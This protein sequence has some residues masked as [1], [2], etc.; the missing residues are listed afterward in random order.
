M[1]LLTMGKV[2]VA[3]GKEIGRKVKFNLFLLFYMFII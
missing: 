1:L 2:L 3:V